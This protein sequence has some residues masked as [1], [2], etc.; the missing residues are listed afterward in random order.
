[1]LTIHDVHGPYEWGRLGNDVAGRRCTNLPICTFFTPA[2]LFHLKGVQ[3]Q[4]V[5]FL[6]LGAQTNKQDYITSMLSSSPWT[7]RRVH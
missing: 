4:N 2:G 7:F 6:V 1:M 5:R 3:D